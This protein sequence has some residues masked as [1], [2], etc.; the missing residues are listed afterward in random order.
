MRPHA[1]FV[2]NASVRCVWNPTGHLR[3]TMRVAVM[4][5]ILPS[6]ISKAKA[7]RGEDVLEDDDPAVL[8]YHEEQ[9]AGA[10]APASAKP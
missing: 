4:T 6:D 9:K 5:V 8:H 2:D 10:R 3:P 1:P 7:R